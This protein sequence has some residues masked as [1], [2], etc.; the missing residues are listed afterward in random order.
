LRDGLAE[1][2]PVA[3]YKAW[4]QRQPAAVQ[5]ELRERWGDPE[6]S[7]M[8]TVDRGEAVFVMPRLAVGKVIFSPQAP[9]GERWEEKEKALYHSS[10]A[11]PSHFYL[12]HYLWLREHF[13]ADALV[14]YGTHGSQEWLP[15]KGAAWP[16]P[17]TRCSPSA[18][19]RSIYIVDNIGEALQAK[20]RGRAVIVTHQ[21]PPFAPAG[22]HES[23]TL[24]HD[25]LHQWLAQDDGAVKDKLAADLKKRVKKE[26]ID[27]DMGW[28]DARIDQDFRAF[29]DELHNHLRV[30]TDGPAA[31]P[32]HLRHAAAGNTGWARYC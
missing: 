14:H 19:C 21:T 13:K 29:I 18:M 7:A 10:K 15:G 31:R 9:R 11:A 3:T 4:L 6:K 8:V 23:L 32:A 25:L 28:S 27:K 24:I 20:R 16:S 5:D 1:R 26:H 17:I 12:A 30:G 2:L 22:L